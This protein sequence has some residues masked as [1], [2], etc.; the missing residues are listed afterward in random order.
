MRTKFKL[1]MAIVCLGLMSSCIREWGCTCEHV[2]IEGEPADSAW[3]SYTTVTNDKKNAQ[4]NC[5]Y[6]GGTNYSG[7]TV[8][9]ET[10]TL[11]D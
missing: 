11:D 9:E 1:L 3:T 8:V 4:A 2:V 6:L 5:E 10:C 7:S